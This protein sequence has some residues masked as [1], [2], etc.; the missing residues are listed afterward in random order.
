MQCVIWLETSA[1]GA[2]RVRAR[3]GLPPRR[4]RRAIGISLVLG[5]A[6]LAGCA[7][8]TDVVDMRDVPQATRDAMLHVQ[9]LP[10][11]T[12]V[13]D[14]VGPLAPISGY[15][16]GNTP[17][18]ASANAVEQLRIKALRLRATAVTD[19]QIGSA[20]SLPCNLQY[21]AIANGIAVAPRGVPPT[22]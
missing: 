6:A 22:Y 7:P 13:P 19:V 4:G 16:C 5:I 15:G 9:V 20:S 2:R 3:D 21:S 10:L 8:P 11:G 12:P 17:V 14:G 18:E 1:Q